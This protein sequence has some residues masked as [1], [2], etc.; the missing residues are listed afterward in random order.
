MLLKFVNNFAEAFF[1][2]EPNMTQHIFFCKDTD[3]KEEL[4]NQS[5][6]VWEM[7]VNNN[8]CGY[9]FFPVIL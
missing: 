2:K 5:S 8:S 3:R 4:R 9:V 6:G 1:E 7:L